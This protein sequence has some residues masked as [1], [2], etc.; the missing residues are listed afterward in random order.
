MTSRLQLAFCC[1]PGLLN[2]EGPGCASVVCL[3][4]VFLL[5]VMLQTLPNY[6]LRSE[7]QQQQGHGT[8]SCPSM[9]RCQWLCRTGSALKSMINKPSHQIAMMRT[10]RVP[11]SSCPGTSC[12]FCFCYFFRLCIFPGV[13]DGN[14]L[15]IAKH[16]L[17]IYG[18][19]G[20]CYIPW[21]CVSATVAQ[22]APL[23]TSC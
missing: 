22:L 4:A 21:C 13:M 18:C 14:P 23:G 11:E 7:R 12:F 3:E 2:M 5:S 19:L 17:Y 10:G 16:G 1:L 8:K 15:F 6:N 20:M 9:K